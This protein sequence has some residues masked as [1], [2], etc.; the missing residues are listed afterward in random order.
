[1]LKLSAN[2]SLLFPELGVCDRVG[3]AARAGFTAVEV[4][5]PYDTP[6]TEL[7]YAL[8][9]NGMELTVLNA[10]PGDYAGGERG[11]ACIPGQEA[12]FREGI[13]QAIDYAKTTGCQSIHVLTGNM[14]SGVPESVCHSTLEQNLIHAAKRFA[15]A[16]VGLL[17]E[18]LSKYVLPRYSMTTVEQASFWCKRLTS[19]GFFNVGLQVDYYH[20]QMEQG[21]LAAITRAYFDDIR[22]VQIAGVPGRHEPTNGEINYR[23]LFKLLET[24]GFAGWVGCEYLPE[25]DTDQGLQWAR[26]WGYL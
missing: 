15:D 6:A 1:M 13:E 25:S 23:Y 14:P 18:P 26:D 11:L 12:K 7:A 20:T 24:L 22:Y 10:P 19:Q 9:A 17:L 2:I 21:N 5:Y 4:M 16:G 8:D 3:A